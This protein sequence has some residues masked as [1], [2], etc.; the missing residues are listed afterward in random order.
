MYCGYC[1]T[2][3]KLCFQDESKVDPSLPTFD[4]KTISK[5][6][7]ELSGYFRISFGGK[8]YPRMY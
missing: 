2:C 8:E 5:A 3:V 7:R 1:V 6:P 4:V